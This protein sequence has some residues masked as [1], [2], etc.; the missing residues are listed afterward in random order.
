[1]SIWI[2]V[3]GAAGAHSVG[4]LMNGRISPQA[5]WY[6][7]RSGE[8]SGRP[9][10]G[11]PKKYPAEGRKASCEA[12]HGTPH[13]VTVCASSGM[14]PGRLVASASIPWSPSVR[15]SAT[16]GTFARAAAPSGLSISSAALPSR[17]STFQTG[18][19]PCVKGS[20]GW[21]W[22]RVTVATPTCVSGGQ[23]GGWVFSRLDGH[24]GTA[25]GLPTTPGGALTITVLVSP[26]ETTGSV[27]TAP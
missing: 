8:P 24:F 25:F 27:A 6:G 2:V 1:M 26:A 9:P 16:I 11:R 14:P 17:A 20:L 5:G 7:R 19:T 23:V 18:N 13:N 12:A 22:A 3:T 21:P 4:L 15:G 10:S